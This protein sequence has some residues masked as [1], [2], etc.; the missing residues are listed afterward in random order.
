M[1]TKLSAL[2]EDVWLLRKGAH[3][4]LAEDDR[5]MVVESWWTGS[6]VCLSGGDTS[7][8]Q[9]LAGKLSSTI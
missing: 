8:T 2:F 6:C 5:I 3:P 1:G 4:K 7:D 9:A